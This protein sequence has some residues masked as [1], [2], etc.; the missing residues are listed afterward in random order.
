MA[1]SKTKSRNFR[2]SD[3]TMTLANA[4]AAKLSASGIRLTATDAVRYSIHR[5]A[6]EILF[7]P[8][9]K[10]T[11]KKIRKRIDNVGTPC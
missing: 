7:G 9:G 1:E 2:L 5:V 4:I 10:K 3:E 11:K 8:D 6:E